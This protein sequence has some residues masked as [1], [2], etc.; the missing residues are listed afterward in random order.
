MLG[1]RQTV[2]KRRRQTAYRGGKTDSFP[3]I[4][5]TDSIKRERQWI[6]VEHV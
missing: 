2:Y 1:D 6:I 4:A 5:G 3:H